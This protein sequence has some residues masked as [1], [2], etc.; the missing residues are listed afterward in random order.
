MAAKDSRWIKFCDEAGVKLPDI[1]TRLYRQFCRNSLCGSCEKGRVAKYMCT[2]LDILV[3]LDGWEYYNLY[4][5]HY[6]YFAIF[7]VLKK[8]GTA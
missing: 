5:W 6:Q 1:G 3:S 4:E 8:L 2:T 7:T